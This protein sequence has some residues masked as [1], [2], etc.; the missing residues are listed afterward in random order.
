MSKQ[1]R[2]NFGPF[3]AEEWKKNFP[4]QHKLLVTA[5]RLEEVAD[6]SADAAAHDLMICLQNGESFE[7]PAGFAARLCTP[8]LALEN[9][10]PG[11]AS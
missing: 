6:K 2:T 4:E 1:F 11:D 9:K 7:K 8:F 10:K 3:L 5:G